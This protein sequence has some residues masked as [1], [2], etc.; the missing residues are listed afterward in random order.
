MIRPLILFVFAILLAGCA[1]LSGYRLDQKFG[2]ANPARFDQP[3]PAHGLL[4]AK[5]DYWKEVKPITDNRC[6]VC[7]GCYDAPCQLQMGSYEGIT[8][9]GNRD[10]VYAMRLLQ[11]EPARLFTDAQ[12]NAQW[13]QRDFHPVLNEREPEANLEAGVMAKLLKLKGQYHYPNNKPLP[14]K[15]FDFSLDRDQQCPSIE[16]FDGF[17]EDHPNWGMPYGLP[18]LDKKEEETLLT[19]LEQGAPAQAAEPIPVEQWVKVGEWEKFLNGSTFKQQLMSRFIY[20]H[21]FLGHFYFD[22]LPKPV[23]FELV[24]S[25]TPPGQPIELIATRRPYDDPGVARVYYRFR[26]LQGALL[27]KTHMPYALNSARMNR[28]QQWFLDDPYAVTQ[29]PSYETEVA[30]NPFIAFTQIPVRARYRLMLDEAQFTV[31]GFIKGPVC[32]GQVALNVINDHFFIVFLS[33]E[34]SKE[35]T[36]KFLADA[37]KNV[38]LPTERANSLMLTKWMGYAKQQRKFLRAK[39]QLIKN[40][41]SG[42]NRP[43]LKFLW[44]GDGT[45]PNAA[46]TVFRHFDSATVVKGLVGERPQTA[47]VMGYPLLER[48]HYLLV[49]GFDIYSNV[50]AQLE[51]RLYMDFLRMEAEFNTLALLPKDTRDAVRDFWY[52]DAPDN[53]KEYLNGNHAYFEPDTAVEFKTD[54]PFGELMGMWKAYLKPALDPR[55]QLAQATLPPEMMEELQTLANL[56]G[57]EISNLPEA[58]FI[59]I[60]DNKSRDYHFTLLRNSAHSNIS[61]LFKEE[62]RRLP[63]ED[64]LTL[65]PGFLGAYPNAFFMV[66]ADELHWFVNKIS[67]LKSESDYQVLLDRYGIRRTDNRFWA[68]SDN[69]NKAFHHAEP[70]EASLFDYNR[71]EN[72]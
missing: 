25:K 40:T 42:E 10:S 52:R 63:D 7:H 60:Q 9:G 20:E 49:A 45:N 50:I 31:M 26:P 66:K 14:S 55:Y 16:Q 64:T 4:K 69:L 27:S 38:R 21:W 37:L 11:A 12:T 65:V 44:D 62:N 71:F 8:R 58:S 41:M 30:S 2:S 19:W 48:I 68:H 13:R 15:D 67:L 39:S 28:I 5:V 56:T 70:I 54:D 17:A 46:L 6:A 51:S 18:A 47:L 33:P 72:R 34:G 23:F 29:L 1:V 3:L 43:N 32:R 22:E 35:E 57:R 59:T 24:R 61:Q 36:Q 53:V